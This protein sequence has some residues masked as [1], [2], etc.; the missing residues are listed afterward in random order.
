[1]IY[2]DWAAT[3]MPRKDI[4]LNSI[5]SSLKLFANP[6]SVHNYGSLA[7]DKLEE[8]RKKC[9]NL[10]NCPTDSIYFTSGGSESNN[11]VLLSFLKKHISGEIISTSIE[12]PSISEPVDILKKFGWKVTN[13]NPTQDGLISLKKLNKSINEKTKIVSLIY[14]HNETGIIQP[15]NQIVDI[16]RKREEELGTKI[17]IHI[18]GVQAVGKINIDIDKMNINS[19]SVSGHKFGAPKGVGILYL[20]KYRDVLCRG[21]GQ[22]SGIRPGTENLSGIMPLTNC[23]EASLSEL[24][25]SNLNILMEKL[26]TGVRNIGID[27]IPKTR[28]LNDINFVPNIL[29]LTCPPLPGEVLARVLDSKGFMISTGSACSSN[30]KS[31]TKGI[32]SMGITEKE[33]FSS[34]RVSIGRLTTEIELDNFLKALE[35]CVKELAP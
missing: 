6:S 8:C 20:N 12:H 18:D 35:E 4:I 13:I 11:I 14:V 10:L 19:F 25:G 34:F 24:E 22:E 5:E 30:K 26:I 28:E 23:L 1:M 27:T 31:T 3:A 17:H 15:I 29:S 32:L 33:G 21:G 16:I 9:G 7:K 2:L